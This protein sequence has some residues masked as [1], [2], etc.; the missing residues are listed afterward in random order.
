[1]RN[2]KWLILAS[3]FFIVAGPAFAYHPL[4]TDD[5]GTTDQRHFEL[6][7]GNDFIWPDGRMDEA[8]GYLALKAGLA[9]GLEFDTA[10]GFAYSMNSGHENVSGFGDA[11][12]ALKWRFLGDN[13][14]PYNL[15]IEVV[16]L[17][18]S[19]ETAKGLSEGDTIIPAALLFGSAGKGPF[20]ALWN[21]GVIFVPDANDL[22]LY[23]LALEYKATDDF[24][25]VGEIFSETDIELAGNDN[26][27]EARVG[28]LYSA[29]DWLTLSAGFGVG[30]TDAS[31]DYH[32]TFATLIG[33]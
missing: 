18:P 10:L 24:A 20:R 14:G 25:L 28:A 1:M 19:G 30:L 11:E 15:G 27:L 31:H 9:P 12:V 23:G 29:A 8:S 21:T 7:W 16:T 17:L 5:P 33:W 6:E 4:S 2:L 22:L 32:F 26:P 13:E 3:L